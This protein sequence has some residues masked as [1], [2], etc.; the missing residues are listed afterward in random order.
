M[1]LALKE[2]ELAA[3]AGEVPVG[4]VIVSDGKVVAKAHN[5]REQ[6]KNALAHAEIA[7]IYKACRKLKSW[8][9]TDCDIYITLEPCPMCAGA[10][11]NSRF[12]RLIFAAKDERCGAVCSVASI[13]FISYYPHIEIQFGLFECESK[14]LMGDFFKRLRQK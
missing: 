1:A 13:P 5:M 7:A 2:A 9:L 10:I 11:M 12:R 6:T 3:A 14:K 8:R 4:A